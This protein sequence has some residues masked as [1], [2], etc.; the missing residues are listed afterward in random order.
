AREIARQ[1]RLRD[2]GG[3]III[4]FIDMKRAQHN[5]RVFD[6]LAEALKRDHAKTDISTVSSLGLVEMTR[7]RV[8]KSLESVVYQSC[9]YCQG[10]GL[11]KSAVTVAILAL[12]RIKKICLTSKGR[13]FAPKKAI[14]VFAHPDVASYLVNE[15]RQSIYNLENRHKVKIL[16]KP[17]SKLHMEELKI[18]R[19]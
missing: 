17:D 19:A 14:I 8:R 4:D 11:V 9:P 3:I 7:Q 10:K 16:I 15:D 13:M 2:I 18:E 1:M 5:K 12:K 6:V